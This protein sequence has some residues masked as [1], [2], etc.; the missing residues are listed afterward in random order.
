[1]IFKNWFSSFPEKVLGIATEGTD[2]FGKQITIIKGD[3]SL[4]SKIDVS[5]ALNPTLRESAMEVDLNANMNI[6]SSLRKTKDKKA[7]NP[8]TKV[9]D[10]SSSKIY[11]KAVPESDLLTEDEA[12]NVLNKNE[13]PVDDNDI[14]V[15]VYHC[16]QNSRPIHPYLLERFKKPYTNDWFKKQLKDGFL[17]FEPSTNEYVPRVIYYQ[18]NILEKIQKL[19]NSSF[20]GETII[21]EPQK[22]LQL[23]ELLKAQPPM[24]SLSGDPK[25]RLTIDPFS[26]FARTY[27]LES[28][29]TILTDFK[30]WVSDAP[31]EMQ[32]TTLRP[33]EINHYGFNNGRHSNNTDPS[34]KLQMKLDLAVEIP[35]L[36][37]I[38][39]SELPHSDK[40]KIELL[41]NLENNSFVDPDY[42]KVPLMFV[43]SRTFKNAPLVIRPEQ[44]EGVAFNE[45]NGTG[46]IGYDVG[47]GKTMTA[48][49]TFAQFMQSGRS[50][51][52]VL[53]VP[54]PTY[55]KWIGEMRGIFNED[56]IL[57]GTGILPQY[58]INSFFNLSVKITKSELIV[59]PNTITILSFQGAKNLGFSDEY[60]ATFVTEINNILEQD[61]AGITQRQKEANRSKSETKVSVGQKKSAALM[62][63][64]DFD[65]LCM[66]EAH[67]ANKIFLSVKGDVKDDGEREKS[68]FA[69]SNGT[70]SQLSTKM[71]FLSQ[72]VQANSKGQG[73]IQL[74]TAT[75][76]TNNPLNVYN[77]FA[78]TN[79][80]R[81]K[82]YGI[83]NVN[84]FFEKYVEVTVDTS[85]NI[86]GEIVEKEVIK[87]WKNKVALQKIMFGIINYKGAKDS[88][89]VK[90][91]NK[92]VMPMLS[93]T[94]N[95][96]QKRLPDNEQILTIL[97]QSDRQ[98]EN[99]SKIMADLEHAQQDMEL[100]KK[101]PFLVAEGQSSN[102][103]LSPYI[104]EKVDPSE[105]TAKE[106]VNDS[107]KIKTMML[108]I[109]GIN[110]WF[111]DRNSPRSC[112]IVYCAIGVDY[113]PLMKKYMM[114]NLGYK[115]KVLEYAKG[116]YFDEVEILAG[117]DLSDDVKEDLK[118]AFNSGIVKIIIGSSTIREGIDLQTRT[119]T[120]HS[121]WVDWNA[122]DYKQLEGRCW[123]FGNM[124]DY[125][126]IIQY[127]V[128]GG[129]DS[130]KF[131][132]LEE[133]TARTN[134]IFDRLNQENILDVSDG[135]RE[136]VKW[137]LV[138]DINEVV[139]QQVK[140]LA[141]AEERKMAVLKSYLE[142][143]ESFE[144]EFATSRKIEEELIEISKE[145]LKQNH[146]LGLELKDLDYMDILK[147]S[148]RNRNKIREIYELDWDIKR[149]ITNEYLGSDMKRLKQLKEK[150]TRLDEYSIKTTGKSIYEMDMKYEIEE[151]NSKMEVIRAE[152]EEI[153]STENK[154][155]LYNEIQAQRLAQD[156]DSNTPEFVA[157][158]ILSLNDRVLNV[159][160][161]NDE[162]TKIAPSPVKV[163]KE[164][165]KPEMIEK[166]AEAGKSAGE[167]LH[168][169]IHVVGDKSLT[170]TEKKHILLML[171]SGL[172]EAKA[173]RKN[174]FI[175][176]LNNGE[177]S[178]DIIEKRKGVG[179]D[180][181]A[182]SRKYT[183]TFTLD[184]KKT[185]KDKKV[186]ISESESI[187]E[188]IDSLKVAL[189]FVDENESKSIKEAIES[190]EIS[191]EFL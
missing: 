169:N 111:D 184:K 8:K 133:K 186:I 178:V 98:R 109:D 48:I 72:F 187:K 170:A 78:L 163:F 162:L 45:I 99:R 101:A 19:R 145:V 22:E 15:W 115:S 69:F 176:D 146:I 182:E 118:Q 33:W 34:V 29:N 107:P 175:T 134:D 156:Q 121:L 117:S 64:L 59:E 128:Q 7:D 60:A 32:L 191:M 58:P 108:V 136:A 85:V 144:S 20:E 5:E 71:F 62:D 139:K 171:N 180:S 2:R 40:Q 104:Y 23:K 158:R 26:K 17:C 149:K 31:T 166:F 189:E 177:Y 161:V 9:K 43:F 164:K 131:Q 127:L 113:F 174:Y 92:V 172:T 14:E 76:F 105:I 79:F 135:D 21:G 181:K 57:E 70:A 130:F 120:L 96:V 114:D 152:I 157:N 88:P 81:L 110:K 24:L 126:R 124:F 125:V 150:L 148:N 68:R 143:Y 140:G 119:S 100:S 35:N 73:N 36:M 80:K 38:F 42:N 50:F 25:F 147:V 122:T 41:W 138:D 13:N 93:E 74:L 44:R 89:S 63:E 183:A 77:I 167:K 165:S 28:E 159:L 155:R 95:G 153:G 47:V 151:I 84:T 10:T 46:V 66:D 168:K 51:K 91:P 188:A 94:I 142:Q 116:K 54:K 56:G 102:N 27:V 52:P 3:L 129:T 179:I 106:F 61:S 1:M 12:F 67:N 185:S 55:G 82:E 86:K 83:E 87:S 30:E 49:L 190:L 123:R 141:Q 53:V 112:Q 97:E 154:E 160:T 4:L 11:L 6:A 137:E 18:G 65:Y 103:S 75:P 16:I 90:R 37:S 173:N 132:K 39:L